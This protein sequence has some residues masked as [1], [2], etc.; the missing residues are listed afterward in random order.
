M[1]QDII[2]PNQRNKGA[3]T[4]RTP[5]LLISMDGGRTIQQAPSDTPPA[6]WSPR[7]LISPDGVCRE[8]I[9][10]RV[11]QDYRHLFARAQRQ[12]RIADAIASRPSKKR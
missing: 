10:L 9:N 8:N 11:G 12:K 1:T 4:P 2:R 3:R 7:F 6:P 5:V